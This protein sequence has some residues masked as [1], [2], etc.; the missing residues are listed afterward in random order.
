MLLNALPSELI[1]RKIKELLW[2]WICRWF[3]GA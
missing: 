2:Q 1:K 3:R